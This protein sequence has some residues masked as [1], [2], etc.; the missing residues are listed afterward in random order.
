MKFSKVS[1]IS[2]GLQISLRHPKTASSGGPVNPWRTICWLSLNQ[3]EATVSEGSIA[4]LVIICIKIFPIFI[5]KISNFLISLEFHHVNHLPFLI[6][7]G[8]YKHFNISHLLLFIM[9]FNKYLL[10]KNPWET[11]FQ[12]LDIL[13]SV[14]IKYAS[15]PRFVANQMYVSVWKVIKTALLQFFI[16]KWNTQNLDVHPTN[17]DI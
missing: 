5:K 4:D 3:D 10:M 8:I 6:S 17:T 13:L 14:S 15:L 1:E 11:S 2:S 16:K 9:I 12:I 7:L